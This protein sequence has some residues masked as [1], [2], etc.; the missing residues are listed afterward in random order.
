MIR[1]ERLQVYDIEQVVN[2]SDEFNDLYGVSSKF[3][4]AKARSLFKQL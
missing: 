4:K 3:N 1:L 2:L